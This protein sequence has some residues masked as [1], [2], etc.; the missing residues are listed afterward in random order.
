MPAIEILGS[1]RIDDRDSAFPSTVQLPN[2]DV[3]CSFS[4]G[5]GPNVGGGTDI[6]RSTDNGQTWTVEGTILPATSSPAT[7][8]SL[9]LSL[10][11]DG[12]TIYAYGAR[13]Y[14]DP[15]APKP[16]D[17]VICRSTDGGR[18]WSPP[19]IVP[20]PTEDMPGVSHGAL[21]LPSGRLLA[22]AVLLPP[23]R[24]GERNIASI[25]DDDGDTWNDHAVVFE[26]PAKK[27]G[28]LE[29]KLAE[30][31]SGPVVAT[32]W[33]SSL[34]GGPD[35]PNSFA[36]SYDDGATWSGPTSTGIM[37]QTMSAVPLG[38][39]RLLLVY[40]RRYGEQGIIAALV[41]FTE[42][43]WTLHAETT[44]YDPNAN[45]DA[46]GADSGWDEWASFEFGFPTAITL[47]DETQ[48]ATHWSKENGKFG[49][50]WTRLRTN[51]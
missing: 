16:R 25:S 49:V 6:A 11:P 28:F 19:H 29:I 5:D 31:P 17:R 39:D 42:E 48:L 14:K 7:S 44:I 23:G 33:T 37:G 45:R 13:G 41:T 43:A 35:E 18:T 1:G 12:A 38:D 32:A 51:F 20:M 40:V 9:K 26:D 2:G 8:N 3:L 46:E 15:D 30:V 27:K 21:P 24:L 22:P 34:E 10:S 50:N 47:K 4:V 36:L